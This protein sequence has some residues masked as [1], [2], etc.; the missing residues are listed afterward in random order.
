MNSFFIPHLGTQIY[1]MSGMEN[2]VHLLASEEG[3][4]PGFSA[5][6]S[7]FGFSGM[8]FTTKAL[9]EQDF[10]HWVNDVKAAPKA[11][12]DA[13]FAKLRE[14]S[15]DVPPAHYSSVNPLLFSHII[16]KYAG[17]LNGE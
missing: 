9:N 10:L 14:K 13:N 16:E 7:G 11:L 4:F 17:A 15:R 5:N 1:A 2:R 8:K 3:D 12:D 6:Y